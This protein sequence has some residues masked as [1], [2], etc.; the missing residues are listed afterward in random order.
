MTKEN[1]K[2]AQEVAHLINVAEDA[3][4]VISEHSKGIDLQINRIDIDLKQ[5]IKIRDFVEV[6][7]N[8]AKQYFTE[9]LFLLNQE[10]S[11]IGEQESEVQDEI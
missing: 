4:F 1:F 11:A 3:E 6:L 2:K 9:Q 5:K 8:T 10:F 7:R